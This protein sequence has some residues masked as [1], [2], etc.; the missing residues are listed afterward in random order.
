MLGPVLVCQKK[1]KKAVKLLCDTLLDVC[2]AL[3]ENLKVLGVDG[4]N[5]I[6]QTC[7]AFLFATL[8]LCIRHIEQNVQRN[9]PQ[10]ATDTKRNEVITAII[11]T[12]GWSID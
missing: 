6:N 3:A 11:G 2:P 8:S 9:L 1:D 5:S 10:N 7:N 4:E 12:C